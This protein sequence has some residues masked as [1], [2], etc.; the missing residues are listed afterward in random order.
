MRHEKNAKTR[1]MIVI[2]EGIEV[3]RAAL[4]ALAR[5]YHIRRLS[6]FGSAA[7]GELRPDSDIDL[8]VEFEEGKGPSLWGMVEVQE[9]FSRLF[10]GRPVDL[11]TPVILEN[12]FRRRTIEPDLKVLIDEAA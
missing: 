5:K 10:G 12:P 3:P 11:V 9:Q 2:G 7:R 6:L 1:E 4:Q 8:L